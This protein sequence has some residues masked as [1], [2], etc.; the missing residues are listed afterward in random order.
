MRSISL[1][2]VLLLGGCLTQPD[3]M[4]AYYGAT[5]LVTQ[6]Y[7]EVDHLLLSPDRTYVMY[8]RRFPVAHGEW[9]YNDGEVCLMPGDTAETRGQRFC[10]VWSGR[11]VGDRW[12]IV[13]G[14]QLV[15]MELAPGR[16]GPLPADAPPLAA[17]PH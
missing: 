17:P 9:S 16:R 11:T 12:S 6:P 15:P 5:V 2:A 10:N 3:P 4:A 14:D 13:T 1:I 8:G 7:G